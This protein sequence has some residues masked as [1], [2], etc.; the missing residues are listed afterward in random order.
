V[1]GMILSIIGMIFACFG[2]IS[3]SQGA[4]AQQIIDIVAILNALRLTI[5]KNVK[6]D[7]V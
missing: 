5:S 6:S 4:I 7:L 1:G 2:F 3:P